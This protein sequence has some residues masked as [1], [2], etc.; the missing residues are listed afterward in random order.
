M[1]H[2]D[3]DESSPKFGFILGTIISVVVVIIASI[4]ACA[5]FQSAKKSLLAESSIITDRD[6]DI[7]SPLAA[8]DRSSEESPIDNDVSLNQTRDEDSQPL[9]E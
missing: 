1:F 9:V 5:T 3:E 7:P 6:M 2:A 8:C 4:V